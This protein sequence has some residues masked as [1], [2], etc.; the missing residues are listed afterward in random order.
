[1]RQPPKVPL[2]VNCA[3]YGCQRKFR[4]T[5]PEFQKHIRDNYGLR[6]SNFDL[7]SG[8]LEIID[9]VDETK[10]E[11][12]KVVFLEFT[13]K[14]DPS[15]D[16]TFCC[17]FWTSKKKE[18]SSSH[19]A[20]LNDHSEHLS[21][22][23]NNANN[24]NNKSEKDGG[25]NQPEDNHHHH[26]QQQKQEQHPDANSKGKGTMGEGGKGNQQR[27]EIILGGLNQNVNNKSEKDG[28]KDQTKAK[29]QHHHNQQQQQEQHPEANSKGKGIMGQGSKGKA[30]KL[31]ETSENMNRRGES[32][33]MGQRPRD[34]TR[35]ESNQ[36]GQV[37]QYSR[38]EIPVYD[39]NDQRGQYS[40]GHTETT[41]YGQTYHTNMHP[42]SQGDQMEG[43]YYR[44]QPAYISPFSDEPT[45][46]G[47]CSIM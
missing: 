8:T 42:M 47:G 31:G 9:D 29:H 16:T 18:G 5:I 15:N 30:I 7:R 24:A 26:H 43:G 36:M 14:Q 19:V 44:R 22:R 2:Q 34:L 39:Q 41:D 28:G 12:L 38:G 46:D 10:L 27:K 1:M 13:K 20:Q 17:C 11:E 4:K 37:G 40:R 25:K 32:G 33:Q 23:N 3:C 6:R 35:N 45:A 21:I